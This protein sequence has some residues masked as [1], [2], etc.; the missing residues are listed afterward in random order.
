MI[1]LKEQIEKNGTLRE[2]EPKKRRRQTVLQE[3]HGDRVEKTRRKLS[4]LKNG[5]PSLPPKKGD[6]TGEES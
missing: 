5:D 1:K 3:D 2:S 6:E 4:Q